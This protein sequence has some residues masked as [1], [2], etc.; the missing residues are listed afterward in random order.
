MARLTINL[1]ISLSA[2]DAPPRGSLRGTASFPSGGQRSLLNCGDTFP[3]SILNALIPP[4]ALDQSR[5]ATKKKVSPLTARGGS[6]TSGSPWLAMGSRPLGRSSGWW[7]SSGPSPLTCCKAPIYHSLRWGEAELVIE[8]SFGQ[9]NPK[10]ISYT[11][12]DCYSLTIL[13][14]SIP[15]ILAPSKVI[16]FNSA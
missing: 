2:E 6:L 16:P 8:R 4:T 11:P 5:A 9:R 13:T 7:R 12:A 15:A 3:D 10:P 1:A 14:M